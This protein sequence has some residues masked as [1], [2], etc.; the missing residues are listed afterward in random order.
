MVTWIFAAVILDVPRGDPPRARRAADVAHERHALAL[1]AAGPPTKT[2]SDEAFYGILLL[3]S[4]VSAGYVLSHLVVERLSRRMIVVPDVQYVVLGVV[5]GPLLGVIDTERAQD[6]QPVLSLG[7]AALGML[8]GLRLREAAGDWAPSIAI[9]VATASMVIGLPLLLLSGLGYDIMDGEAWTG[10]VIGAGVVA[11]MT[12]ETT[13]RAMTSFLGAHGPGGVRAAGVATQTTALAILGYG[14]L[15]ALVASGSELRMRSPLVGLEAMGIELAGGILLGLLFAASVYRKLDDR[16]LLA[17]LVGT[18]FLAAGIARTTHVSAIFVSFA[19]GV[20]FSAASRRARE[21][22]EKLNG[23]KR[24][25]V[26]VLFF[27]AGL[28]WVSGPP[29]TLALVPA[30]LLLRWLGRRVG[31]VVGKRLSPRRHDYSVAVL[32]AGGLTVALMLGLRLSFPELPGLRETYG[33]LLIAV[34]LTDLL[35][36]RP[37]R[38][39]IIDV[40]DV[41]PAGR[42]RRGGFDL[43]VTS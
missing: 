19:A 3:L 15:F 40:D 2:M 13:V 34:V 39:W 12:T 38:R 22:T 8:A 41:P 31:G 24:P 36:V 21:V 20:T 42:E 4:A 27:F 6:L 29:W 26:I 25:F 11:L 23:I 1:E 32:P 17:V 10:A 7:G 33:A 16:V 5:L 9:A 18:I 35:S 37:I 14:I 28:E 43:G 30:Y